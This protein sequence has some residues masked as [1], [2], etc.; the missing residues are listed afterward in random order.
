[1][2]VKNFAHIILFILLLMP[3][4]V[5]ATEWA[6]TYGGSGADFASPIQQ[7]TDG[8][9]IVAGGT[10]S[11]SV[12]GALTDFWVVK[13]DSNG[14]ITWQKTYGGS[15]ADFA[16]SIQQ[17]TDGGYIVAGYTKSFGAGNYDAWV[18]KL[19][20]NG[21]VTWQKTYG[22]SDAD[23]ASSIQQTTDGGYIVA[24]YSST[25]AVGL[26]WIVK[27]D[28]SGNVV[29]QKTYGGSDADFASSIQQTTDG[30]YIV[31]GE[32]HSFGAGSYDAWVLKLDSNG[33]INWQKTYWGSDSDS[34][35]SI[36]QTADGGY[37]VAGSTTDYDFWVLKL[38]SN[39][40]ITWQKTC[41]GSD[42]EEASSIQQTTDGGYIVGGTTTSFGAGFYDAW[43]L[44]LDSNGE[45]SGCDTIKTSNALVSNTSVTPGNSSVVGSTSNALIG[46]TNIQPNVTSA[47]VSTI[48]ETTFSLSG[49][50]SGDVTE[51]IT[52]TLFG[53]LSEV[54]LTNTSGNYNFTGLSNGSYTVTPNKYLYTFTPAS[55]TVSIADSDLT[56]VNFTS[57]RCIYSISPASQFFVSQ[58]G[59][60][61]INVTSSSNCTWYTQSNAS[62]ITINSGSSGAGN[63]MV[64][65]SVSVNAE[66]SQ[67]TGTITIAGETFTVTQEGISTSTTW[68]D[69]IA[70]YNDYVNGQ[71]E[72][73]DVIATYQEYVAH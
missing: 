21:N 61:V 34:A 13:L 55:R 50:L 7:T 42:F 49:T 6:K 35:S 24:V 20:S 57:S 44:K 1:M 31:A 66:T 23:D 30:G 9:Y 40:N 38:D 19:D 72:W 45:I 28:S 65:Y 51:G 22:G 14:N 18:V 62:W 5:L 63:G 67:R 33:N 53:S 73:D 10:S 52:M 26:F 3:F 59:T 15:D 54:T 69:V 8:G 25:T 47:A 27:L 11:F 17:T 32:T 16:S 70:K 58:G 4:P 48:C 68:S 41:G 64:N 46:S 37:I 60:G 56:G 43:I 2:K 39:G 29:W 12:F 36:R 71:A